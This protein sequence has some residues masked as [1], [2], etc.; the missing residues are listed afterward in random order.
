MATNKEKEFDYLNNEANL[1]IY[2]DHLGLT[3][4]FVKENKDKLKRIEDKIKKSLRDTNRDDPTTVF[5][6][7]KALQKLTEQTFPRDT[8]DTSLT[9]RQGRG[10]QVSSDGFRMIFGDNENKE[11][12]EIF[13]FHA[14][15]FSNYRNLVSEYRNIARLIPE[16]NRCADMKSRDILAINEITKKAITNVYIPESNNPEA[17][18]SQNLVDEPINAEIEEKILDKYNIEDRLPRYIKTAL[19]EG[20]KPVV[21]YPYKD[22][23]EMAKYNINEYRKQYKDFNSKYDKASQSNEA[24][25][26]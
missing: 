10:D 16:I 20:A 2:A 25:V 8:Y 7:M 23:I 11:D 15:I 19:I 5:N 3:P 12:S 17:K 6:T 22:V 21:V 26:D 14:N 18:L 13:N 9:G 1:S 4:Q 24:L